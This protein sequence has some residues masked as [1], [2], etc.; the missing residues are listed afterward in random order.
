MDKP[1]ALPL[2]LKDASRSIPQLPSMVTLKR[3]SASGKLDDAVVGLTPGRYQSRL[4][5]RQKL[6]EICGSTKKSLPAAD[7]TPHLAPQEANQLEQQP[8][9]SGARAD[10]QSVEDLKRTMLSLQQQIA[11]MKAHVDDLVATKRT[12]QLKY[13]AENQVLRAQRD[14]LKAEVAQLRSRDTQ[15]DA[16]RLLSKIN[17]IASKLGL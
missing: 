2:T 12:L 10:A 17:Q 8:Q 9:Q 14:E 5:D 7:P 13:D 16:A 1:S 6:L 3:L 4:Y 11:S 15:I